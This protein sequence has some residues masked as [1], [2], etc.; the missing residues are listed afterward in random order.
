MV[1]TTRFLCCF[2]LTLLISQAAASSSCVSYLHVRNHPFFPGNPNP[3][4]C[5]LTTDEARKTLEDRVH[6][7]CFSSASH[8]LINGHANGKTNINSKRGTELGYIDVHNVRSLPAFFLLMVPILIAV[9]ELLRPTGSYAS[10]PYISFVILASVLH[11]CV[12]SALY[13]DDLP[14]ASSSSADIACCMNKAAEYLVL[15]QP[16]CNGAGTLIAKMIPKLSPFSM[17]LANHVAAIVA[18]AWVACAAAAYRARTPSN[19]E[20]LP[21]LSASART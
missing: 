3:A 19:K 20:V 16:I 10:T 9:T 1:T 21:L 8:Q 5:S 18:L 13:M 11:V 17:R 12:M 2:S 14:N 15:R 7:A 6:A 4:G